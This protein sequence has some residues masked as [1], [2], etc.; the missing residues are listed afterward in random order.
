MTFVSV[1]DRVKEVADGDGW[2]G[3][4]R[5]QGSRWSQIGNRDSEA[6]KH[7]GLAA[8][9]QVISCSASW[10]ITAREGSRAL[11]VRVDAGAPGAR[12]GAFVVICRTTQPGI[13]VQER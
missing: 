6:R 8:E 5:D 11:Q 3:L 9:A 4:H 13:A 7:I 12:P 2:V 1:S 10:C